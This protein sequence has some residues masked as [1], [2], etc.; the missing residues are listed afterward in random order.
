MSDN[1]AF[2]ATI[3]AVLLIL[4]ITMARAK[5]P[6]SPATDEAVLSEILNI[7]IFCGITKKAIENLPEREG[8]TPTQWALHLESQR[9][10]ALVDV[11]NAR[12][13]QVVNR[14]ID[15]LT[16]RKDP[17]TNELESITEIF[18]RVDA[19]LTLCEEFMARLPSAQNQP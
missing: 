13:A 15:R 7:M 8:L 19:E 2:F 3:V 11:P 17:D 10:Q 6:L 4:S 16:P 18:H 5:E 14:T 1:N 12:F 9:H